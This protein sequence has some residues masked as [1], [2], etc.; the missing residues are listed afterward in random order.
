MFNRSEETRVASRTA[1]EMRNDIAR[2]MED[3]EEEA[4]PG[5]F[6]RLFRR[7]PRE[8]EFP[9]RECCVVGVL[10]ILDRHLALD[11]LVTGISEE[12]A[13]FRQASTFIFDRM[14]AEVSIRFG[15]HDQRGRITAVTPNG[16]RI[17]F[18]DPMESD[19]IDTLIL[20]YGVEP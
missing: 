17:A 5:F 14:G 7:A 6:A 2:Q 13:V 18:A 12:V 10:M 9:L 8:E 1:L 4:R 11:G 16:Y 15:D 20:D 19:D 3:E